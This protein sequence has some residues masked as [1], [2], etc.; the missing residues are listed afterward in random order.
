MVLL[1]A[2]PVSTNVPAALN[3]FVQVVFCVLDVPPDL[4]QDNL[5]CP[6]ALKKYLAW[7]A[8]ANVNVFVSTEL[9]FQAVVVEVVTV[10]SDPSAAALFL[11]VFTASIFALRAA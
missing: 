9:L 6:P 3:K 4:L 8:L 10:L 7:F 1:A 5:I 11:L 2:A